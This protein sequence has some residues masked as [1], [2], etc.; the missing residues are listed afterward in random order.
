MITL[1]QIKD[2]SKP[3]SLGEGGR[4]TLIKN[5]VIEISIV[6]GRQGLYGDFEDDFEVAIF[7]N[8]SGEFKTRFFFPEISD[9][10]IPYFSGEKLE[11]LVNQLI[12]GDDFQVR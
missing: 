10:V 12:K 11:Q 3:H 4:R 8:Q 5:K 2:W 7:D 9:D 6:G 1:S